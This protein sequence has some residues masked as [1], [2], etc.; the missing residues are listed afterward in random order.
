MV[1]PGIPHRLR[2]DRAIDAILKANA[3]SPAEKGRREIR[4]R[5]ECIG[6]LISVIST[7][8]A[9]NLYWLTPAW[10]SAGLIR[11]A[12]SYDQAALG[13]LGI[14]VFHLALPFIVNPTACWSRLYHSIIDHFRFLF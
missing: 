12:A 14:G 6:L 1:K 4:L 8:S 3:P 5:A 13:F 11:V 7:S 9:V 2:R 10:L